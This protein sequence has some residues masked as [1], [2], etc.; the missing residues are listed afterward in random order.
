MAGR[1]R[2]ALQPSTE[3]KMSDNITQPPAPVVLGDMLPEEVQHLGGLRQQSE[4]IVHQIGMNRV[5][6]N[7]LMGQLQQTEKAAQVV[8]TQAGARLGI[9]DGTAWSVTA[10]GKAI[11]VA[12][13]PPA[14][15]QAPTLVPDA[16]GA[17]PE[18]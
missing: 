1:V 18:A 16:D 12:P 8:L 2:E 10:E 6:E 7:R 17:A 3:T 9:P 14:P 5:Q 15:P 13:A 11:Q 4:K